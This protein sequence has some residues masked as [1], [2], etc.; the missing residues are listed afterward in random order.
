MA[1]SCDDPKSKSEAKSLVKAIKSFEFLLS[2]VIWYEILF[3]INMVSK[4]LQSKS[5]CIDA[6]INQLQN[7]MTF[8][9][10]FRNEGFASSINIAKTIALEMGVE[11]TFPHRRNV[12]RKKQFDES[13][14]EE[15]EI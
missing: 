4:K 15:E 11:P 2:M 3:A 7:V 6:T 12:T 5:I 10:K 8:F 14:S 13:D 9:K 1:K